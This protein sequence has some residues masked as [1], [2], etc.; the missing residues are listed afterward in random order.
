MN[1]NTNFEHDLASIRNIME[2]ST[3]FISLSGLAGV[4]AGFYALIAAYVVYSGI[5]LGKIS[6]P[7]D[8]FDFFPTRLYQL[9]LVGGITLVA[10]LITGW[11]FS[12][13]KAR[14]LGYSLWNATTRQLLI[15]LS[16][17]LMTGGVFVL[18]MLWHGFYGLVA[19]A[20]LLFYGL[21]LVSASQNLFDEVRYL[22]YLE[23]ALGLIATVFIGYGLIF[24]A[25]GFGV[26]HIVYGLLMYRKYDA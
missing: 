2:R 5:Y 11:Y 4:L 3:K 19:P 26:L 9:V 18:I 25:I 1:E 7:G 22:G 23:I 12:Q 14:R 24:W 13:R 10:S 21:A 15:N 6:R 16:I 20:T 17:P 8:Y